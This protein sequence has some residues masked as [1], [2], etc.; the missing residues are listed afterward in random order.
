MPVYNCGS[1]D[2]SPDGTLI[3]Y[4]TWR[5]GQTWSES[6]VAV[7]RADGTDRRLLGDGAM[8]SWSPDGTHL[9]YSPYSPQGIV[10]MAADGRGREMIAYHWGSPRWSPRGN[11]IA[12]CLDGNIG[13]FDLTTGRESTT[14]G[15]T[16]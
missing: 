8:P 14:A 11:R 15:R 10:V 1:P 3:A 7:I 4:D 9:V 2:W 13:L 12:T 16:I 5:I 6:K